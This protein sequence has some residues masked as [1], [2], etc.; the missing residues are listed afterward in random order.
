M[1]QNQR[2][3]GLVGLLVI[4]A[5]VGMVGFIGWY[6]WR[7]SNEKSVSTINSFESCAAAGNPI[8]ESYPEQCSANG[9]TFT[10]P[11]QT[12]PK[13]PAT[14]SQGVMASIAIRKGDCIPPV[15]PDNNNC[16]V[17]TYTTPSKVIIKKSVDTNDKENKQVVK[18]IENVKGE[19][20]VELPV[21]AYNMYVV[22]EGKE[23]C[24]SFGGQKG[25]DCEFSV[26]PGKVT[27]YT[28]QINTATD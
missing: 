16:I 26:E 19:F 5:V 22:Y 8:M 4:I 7:Q 20:E 15:D 18:E 1:K 10:N 12:A 17:E 25:E 14:I 21:G 24:N 23:Y 11:K 28:L 13:P 6:I 27:K 9:K 2:G 3:F